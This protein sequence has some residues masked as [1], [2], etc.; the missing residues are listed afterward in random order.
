MKSF[1]PVFVLFTAFFAG[2]F[3]PSDD[4]LWN[5][6]QKA[7]EQGNYHS[8][9]E[10]CNIII[11]KHKKSPHRPEALYNN[12]SIHKNF[13]KEYNSSITM[14]RQ[15]ASE[16]PDHSLTPSAMFLVGFIFNN[17]LNEVDSARTT[18]L[19]F[20]E[21]YPDHEMVASA[22]FELDNLGHSP[23]DI[24]RKMNR[25]TLVERKRN[26]KSSVVPH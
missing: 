19:L 8:V 2:C 15:L 13:L 21:K 17:D 16:Y 14:F 5:S 10:S 24:L 26:N 23:E 20:L 4:E 22:R 12:A 7:L 6:A 11:E 1:I 18:Y 25:E 3:G 9:I